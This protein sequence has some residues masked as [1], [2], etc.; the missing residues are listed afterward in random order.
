MT[1]A[2]TAPSEQSSTQEPHLAATCPICGAS[3]YEARDPCPL[4]AAAPQLLAALEAALPFL[5]NCPEGKGD[6][7]GPRRP[8]TPEC[9]YMKARAVIN[10]ARKP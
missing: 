9:E 5:P 8:Y 2:S 4:H 10:A 1:D 3:G 6:N 7:C